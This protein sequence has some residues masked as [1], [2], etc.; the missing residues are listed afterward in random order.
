MG[1]TC[2]DQTLFIIFKLFVE[3]IMM[4]VLLTCTENV[5][6]FSASALRAKLHWNSLRASRDLWKY[7]FLTTTSITHFNL[8]AQWLTVV[9]IAAITCLGCRDTRHKVAIKITFFSIP[10]FMVISFGVRRHTWFLNQWI[11]RSKYTFPTH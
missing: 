10:T 8:E 5:H 9:G 1:S 2:S 11:F 6:F 3:A 4:Y 7:S